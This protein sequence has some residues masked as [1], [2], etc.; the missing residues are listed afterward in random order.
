MSWNPHHLPD[1]HRRRFAITGSTAGIG[2]FASEQLAAAGAHVILMGRSPA[3]LAHARD[4]IHAHAPGSSVTTV[5]LDLASLA[6]VGSA[7]TTLSEM[8]PIDGLFLNGGAMETSVGPL[9]VDGLPMMLGTHVVAGFALVTQLLPVLRGRIV[10]ASTGF[11]RRLR[12][13]VDDVR[14]PQRGFF[15]T[16]TQAKTITELY[17]YELDRRLRRDDLPVASIVAHPGIGVDAKTPAREGVYDPHT[18]RRRNPFTPWAQGKDAAAWPAV[19]ALTDADAAG[20]EYYGPANGRRGIPARL[21]PLAHTA[22]ADSHR[23]ARVWTQLEE[24]SAHALMR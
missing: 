16:Y 5:E 22:H 1:L 8:G 9:T 20:G 7:A 17:A 2:Y 6:S 13:D 19:R 12:L 18:Q 15:R 21:V 23:V 3:K 10:H 24:L 4:A 14:A 11:V